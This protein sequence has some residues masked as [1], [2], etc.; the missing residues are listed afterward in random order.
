MISISHILEQKF[1]D[2]LPSSFSWTDAMGERRA[3]GANV[4]RV[5]MGSDCIVY[6]LG[7]GPFSIPPAAPSGSS[8]PVVHVGDADA[9]TD[10]PLRVQR[11]KFMIL[12]VLSQPGF[13]SSQEQR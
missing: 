4:Y 3:V 7:C 6:S 9:C 1:G 12:F 5:N 11:E 2:I 10:P 13:L 8:C